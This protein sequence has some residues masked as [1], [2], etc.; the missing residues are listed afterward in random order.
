MSSPEKSHR[1]DWQNYFTKQEIGTNSPTHYKYLSFGWGERYFF[2]TSPTRIELVVSQVFKALFLPTRSVM[3]VQGHFSIPQNKEVKC[4]GV[5]R[6]D[7][8]R[9]IS[10]G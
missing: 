2:M 7:Y 1:F 10:A 8:W 6:S 3:R 5:S 4:V 9:C